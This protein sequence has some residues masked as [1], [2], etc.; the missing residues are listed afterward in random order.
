MLARVARA[1]RPPSVSQRRVL[2]ASTAR[3]YPHI[4]QHRVKSTSSR[5]FSYGGSTIFKLPNAFAIPHYAA[6]TIDSR[7][8]PLNDFQGLIRLCPS[9]N[10][11]AGYETIPVV[12]DNLMDALTKDVNNSLIWRSRNAEPANSPS[13]DDFEVIHTAIGREWE[14]P[15]TWMRFMARNLTWEEAD[16]AHEGLLSMPQ[17]DFCDLCCRTGALETDK[18]VMDLACGAIGGCSRT[19]TSSNLGQDGLCL[20]KTHP[21]ETD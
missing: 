13:F 2:Q 3:T 7:L 6:T 10:E 12:K 16:Y 8:R 15:R 14:P 4:Q 19:C 18:M 11:Q 1:L 21:W 17:C 5:P 20:L 9:I